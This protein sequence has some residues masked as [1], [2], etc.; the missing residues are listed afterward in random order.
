MPSVEQIE[1]W[2]KYEKEI[3][4][5]ISMQEINDETLFNAIQCCSKLLS[6]Y[7]NNVKHFAQQGNL[8]AIDCHLLEIDRSLN[9]LKQ[10]MR[11]TRERARNNG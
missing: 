10:Y 2:S 4:Q 3:E 9:A 6:D 8:E 7:M 11:E 5:F 1:R